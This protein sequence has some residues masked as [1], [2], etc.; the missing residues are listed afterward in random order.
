MGNGIGVRQS[1]TVCELV[2]VLDITQET[3]LIDFISM[4]LITS[5]SELQNPF[6]NLRKH[7]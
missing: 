7:K 6:I 4:E 3:V 1:N 5:T 2:R